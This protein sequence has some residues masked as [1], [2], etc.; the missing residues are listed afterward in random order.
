M[1]PENPPSQIESPEATPQGAPQPD[2]KAEPKGDESSRGQTRDV[3][4]SSPEAIPAV[5]TQSL[6]G[7]M[8]KGDKTTPMMQQ[9][10]RIKAGHPDAL[11]LFRL[12]DFY[13]LFGADAQEA[14]K[15]LEITLTARTVGEGRSTK[16]P[17]CGVPH[18]AADAYINRLLKNGRKVAIVEQMEDPRKA[19]GMVKR[20]LVRIITPGTVLAPEALE[21]RRNNYLAALSG[22]QGR[23][24]L[25]VAELTTGEFQTIEF[26]GERAWLDLLLELGRL[27]PAEILLPDDWD[28]ASRRQLISEYATT[29]TDLPG[30]RFDPDAG[31]S[32]LLEF[33][34]LLSL[35][36]FGLTGYGPGLGSA[37]AALFYLSD[38]QRGSLH[39][40]RKLAPY[41]LGTH[42]LL[43]ETTIR[44]LELVSNLGDGS[45]RNTLLEVL[46]HCCTAMGSRKLRQWLLRPLLDLGQIR[47][48]QDAVAELAEK[49]TLRQAL[50]ALLNRMHD[51]ERL[52]GRVGTQSASPRDLSALAAT[53]RTLPELKQI[54]LP[55]GSGLLAGLARDLPECRSVAE[56]LGRA[57]VDQPPLSF[58]EGGLIRAGYHAQVDELRGLT[59]SGRST[60]AGLQARERE[61]TGIA[62]LK[63]EYNQVFGYYFEVSKAN[64]KLVPGHYQRKQTLVNSERYTTPELQEYE[65]KVVGAQDQLMALEEELFLDLRRQ[66]GGQLPEIQLA[67][68][69]IAQLD[70]LLSLA[71]CGLRH[72]YCRPRVDD[73]DI[74]EIQDGRHPVVELLT[75]DKFVPN[76]A[77]LDKDQNKVLIITGPNMAGKSTYLRQTALIVIMAQIGSLVPA[78]AARIGLVDRV[79]TRVGAADNLARG[80]STFMVEMN[81]TAN[82]LHNASPRALVILDEVGRGT[83]TFDG[84]SIAWAVAE[85]LHDRVDAK[86]LFATHY[87]ELTELPLSKAQIKNFNIA[88]REWKEQIIFLRKIVAGSADRSYGIQV[89]RLAGLPPE[90]ISRAQEV[91]ANLEKANYTEAGSSRLAEHAGGNGPA[92]GQMGLFEE[93]PGRELARWIADLDPESMTPLEALNALAALKRKLETETHG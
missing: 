60:I 76:S 67:A 62:S 33:F 7:Q 75:S 58:K 68:S 36:G 86:T 27:Q 44:N 92:S 45:R 89:A 78:S 48:R 57:L 84:V 32:Q 34:H 56:L 5:S 88:V 61:Q 43:D 73:Q 74:L 66:V 47:A 40:I 15:L 93:H 41:A 64:A 12:G 29:L 16:I 13:E 11:L 70:A 90:V 22:T 50:A 77:L 2:Q 85:Y 25:A 24:G 82:I 3:Q 20:E 39:H 55:A 10:Q 79:F 9:Y 14:S 8:A 28:D 59:Q 18:H 31:R 37:A 42:M 4:I 21:A 17:M 35:D 1:N 54:L 69:E 72:C 38:T 87:Y 81:E 46:D 65:Q 63:V 26:N 83:S 30:Y 6:P 91:L 19:K 71:E 51:L 23:Y 49:G 80:Q 53:L 52:A